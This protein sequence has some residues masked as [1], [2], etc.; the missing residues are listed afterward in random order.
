MHTPPRPGQVLEMDLGCLLQADLP[1]E[2]VE[3][4][5]KVFESVADEM[6]GQVFLDGLGKSEFLA[7]EFEVLLQNLKRVVDAAI[8][9]PMA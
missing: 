4:G 1:A 9:A 2:T 8:G 3:G 7:R 6:I 5:D